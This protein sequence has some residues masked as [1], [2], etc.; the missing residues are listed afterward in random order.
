M[1]EIRKDPKYRGMARITYGN[2]AVHFPV[3]K[4]DELAARRA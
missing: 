1:F 3:K 2:E 4:L